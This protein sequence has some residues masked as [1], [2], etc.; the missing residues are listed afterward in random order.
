MAIF[1][2]IEESLKDSS[3]TESKNPYQLMVRTVQAIKSNF[4]DNL[5]VIADVALDPYTSHG[6]DGVLNKQGYVDN[7]ATVACLV[8][9]ANVL[10]ASGCDILAPSDLVLS[11]PASQGM[12]Q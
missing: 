4:G 8:E 5:G 12:P 3:G 11:P 7:D 9:Q 1:P 10:A 2:V 6:H